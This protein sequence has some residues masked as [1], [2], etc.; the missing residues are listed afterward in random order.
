MAKILILKNARDQSF[1]IN[2]LSILDLYVPSYVKFNKMYEIVNSCKILMCFFIGRLVGKQ[3]EREH[4]EYIVVEG[5]VIHKQTR[6]VLDTIKGLKEGKW[7]FVMS[8]SKK[9]YA[10]EVCI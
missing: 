8:T 2:A 1:D 9:L 3:Q 10:G 5:R 6:N 7:I 4:Y